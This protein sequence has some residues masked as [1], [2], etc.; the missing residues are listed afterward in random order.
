MVRSILVSDHIPEAKRVRRVARR[1]RRNVGAFMPHQKKQRPLP[2]D[3]PSTTTQFPTIHFHNPFFKA[4]KELTA[5][6]K[7]FFFTAITG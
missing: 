3:N 1:S 5:H 7:A 6:F 4:L 2:F